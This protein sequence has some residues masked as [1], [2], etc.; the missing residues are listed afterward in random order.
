[1]EM[2]NLQ[3]EDFSSRPNGSQG[4]SKNDIIQLQFYCQ[5]Q[6]FPQHLFPPPQA[7]TFLFHNLLGCITN[8]IVHKPLSEE[9]SKNIRTID[10]ELEKLAEELQKYF[11]LNG[12]A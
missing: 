8:S 6:S 12:L 9:Y 1:M 7:H 3:F 11:Q 10:N 5:G 4:E 2:Y